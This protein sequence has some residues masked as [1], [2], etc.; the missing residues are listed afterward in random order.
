MFIGNV[1]SP[2]E[3]IGTPIGFGKRVARISNDV[4]AKSTFTL[5]KHSAEANAASV[6]VHFSWGER[7]EMSHD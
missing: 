5:E 7:V 6:R 3:A 1:S 4:L 2:E